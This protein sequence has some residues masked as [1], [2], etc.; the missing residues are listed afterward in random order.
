MSTT[1]E[2]GSDKT[3]TPAMRQYH[4]IKRQVPDAILFFRMGDFYEMFFD[5]A[6]AAA[7]ALEITLTSRQKDAGGAAI[8]MCGVPYHAADTYIGRL[9]RRG[10]KV[11]VCDQMEDAKH[12]KGVV[13]RDLVRVVTPST[14][15][16]HG[17]LEAK[18]PSY[19][20]AVAPSKASVGVSLADLSTGDFVALEISGEDRWERLGETV[21]TYRPREILHPEGQ[22]L[23]AA[24]LEALGADERP[25]ATPREAW[26]FEHESARSSLLRHFRTLSLESFGLEGKSLAVA[27]AGAALQY[28]EET[29]KGELDHF[30]TIRSLEEAD[31]LV[32]DPVTQRNLELLRSQSEGGREGSLIAVLDRTATAMGARTLRGWLLR[33]L[34]RLDEIS[35]R[36]DAVEELAFETIPR[37]KAREQLKSVLD[38]E[39][40]LSRIILESAGP[41]DFVGLLSSLSRVPALRALTAEAR[42]GLLS[43]LRAQLDPLEDV[44]SDIE[45]TLVSEP[46]ATLKDGGAIREGVSAELDEIRTLRSHGR[47]TL[48]RIETRERQRTGIGSLKVRFNKIFGYYIEVTKSNL[49]A[50]PDDYI[51][52][53]TLVGSERY[54]TPELKDYE[55][56]I[57][58]A[59]ERIQVL[60]REIFSALNR[61]VR[62]Q[63]HRIRKTAQ[64]VGE[65]DVLLS[66]A[67]VAATSNYTKPRLHDAFALELKDARHPVIEA[68]SA[69]PFVG[70]D[71]SLDEER[72]LVILTGPNM[73]GK[74]TY[75]RQTAL[76]VLMAHMGSFVPATEAKIPLVDRIFTRVG[77]S[78]NLYRGR[79]TFM[80]EMQ[81]TA[82]ILN[83]ATRRSLILLDEI[84]RGTATYDGL[85]LAWSVAEHIA[86]EPRLKSKT[87][88]ATHY[89]ELTDLAAELPG[90]V[91]CHVSA[92]EWHDDI[93]FLRKVLEG[94]SDRSYGIQVARLAGLP[95]ALIRRAQEILVNLEKNEFDVE[96]RPR[97]AGESDGAPGA[98]QLSLFAD[99]EDRIISELQRIDPDRMTPLEALRLLSELK[100]RLT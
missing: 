23:P 100:K 3:G 48:A 70:N 43:R 62:E 29:Q 19:L 53:Q 41:R 36:L 37:G 40:I 79:S 31:A 32:L 77:A 12:A 49:G 87:I 64:A 56:R 59:E 8:P 89:H 74:S 61:R 39:R 33:P 82:H 14:Y 24:V 86:R 20:L 55:E 78:D 99:V 94:G 17:Y 35:D 85:S 65:L 38:L 2:R 57:L 98:R 5:D 11:A 9:I 42:A 72:H 76:I 63:A 22:A 25:V 88:F 15:L 16:H 58:N 54:V 91:N 84:G 60:E 95:P 96:G 97:L 68:T 1:T 45:S 69:E 80:V 44:R 4:D 26:R 66:L 10:F 7:R 73:G 92:R 52:K 30:T 51:R 67:E 47:E 71:L 81:E 13:K 18:E 50:V 75:L 90:V 46:P 21:S 27:A 6:L 93:V 34:L 28:L 83:H